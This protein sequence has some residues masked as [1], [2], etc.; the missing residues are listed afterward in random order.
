MF[1]YIHRFHVLVF[2][3]NLLRPPG[4]VAATI[5][6]VI[7]ANTVPPTLPAVIAK[8][9]SFSQNIHKPIGITAELI[10]TPINKYTADRFIWEINNTCYPFCMQY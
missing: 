3:L 6:H 1:M 4:Y 8:P 2:S 7:S 5:S 10:V 9:V